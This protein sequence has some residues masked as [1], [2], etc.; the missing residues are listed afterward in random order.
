[1][2]SLRQE[3]NVIYEEY[4]IDQEPL[5]GVVQIPVKTLSWL[6]DQTI[7]LLDRVDECE[8]T[9]ECEV[10]EEAPY[11]EQP[12]TT[13]ELSQRITDVDRRIGF[14]SGKLEKRIARLA[15]ALN[16]ERIA[17]LKM[18]RQMQ[19]FNLLFPG[20]APQPGQAG[21][22]FAAKFPNDKE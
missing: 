7:N 13:S 19:P 4:V 21:K 17:R 3:I 5:Y 10:E 8:R 9:Q 12:P 20:L 6:I 16:A 22:D 11:T 14:V 1:M 18:E 2:G 15:D